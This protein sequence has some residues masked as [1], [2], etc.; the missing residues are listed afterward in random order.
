MVIK[1]ERTVYWKSIFCRQG[2]I[3]DYSG[4]T[5]VRSLC[6]VLPSAVRSISLDTELKLLIFSTDDN[7]ITSTILVI[8]ARN[9]HFH[10]VFAENAYSADNLPVACF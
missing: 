9:R 2:E 3:F 7:F 4:C 10:R 5:D 6:M 1:K 8:S